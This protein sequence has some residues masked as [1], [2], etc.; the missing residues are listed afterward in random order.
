MT[1]IES[2]EISRYRR[3][4]VDDMAHMLKKYQ[5]IMEWDV[6]EANEQE[7]RTLILKAMHEALAQVEA[8]S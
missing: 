2:I 4:I 8:G 7:A 5:R 3:E 1:D 6:P